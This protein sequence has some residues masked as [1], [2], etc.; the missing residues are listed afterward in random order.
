MSPLRKKSLIKTK[1]SAIKAQGPLTPPKKSFD[2]NDFRRSFESLDTQNSGSWPLPVKVTV[3]L[4]I[5][6][7]IAAM[8]WA[9]PISSKIDE[10]KAS[11]SE[12]QTLLETYRQKESRARHLNTYKAQVAQMDIEFNTLLDQLP[13]DC[14]LYTSPRPRDGLLSRMPSSA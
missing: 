11:E 12:Q 4:L 2:F 9:L 6:V 7:F 14:L 3:L 8:A 10:I 5:V 13:K 1:K